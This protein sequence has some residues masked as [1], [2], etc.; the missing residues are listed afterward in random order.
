MRNSR[1]TEAQTVAI[2]Q[3][4]TAGA[5]AR[6]VCRRHAVSEKTYHRW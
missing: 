4:V 6:E 1:L 5:A 2:L 3:E